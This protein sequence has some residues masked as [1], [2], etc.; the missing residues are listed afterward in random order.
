MFRKTFDNLT[1]LV[2]N[3]TEMTRKVFGERLRLRRIHVNL[4]LRELAESIGVSPATVY[5][6]EVGRHCP[7]LEDVIAMAPLLRVSPEWFLR[8]GR[9]AA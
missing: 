1:S 3:E 7:N 6:W 9:R 5:K 8:S 4:S 2:E